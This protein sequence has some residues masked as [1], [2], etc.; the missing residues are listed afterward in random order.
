MSNRTVTNSA[1]EIFGAL[2]DPTRR[3]VLDLLCGGRQPA[4]RIAASFNVS[5]PAVTKHVRLLLRARL[6]REQ[7]E[8]RYRFYELNAEPL[9][10]VDSWLNRYKVFWSASLVGLKNYVESEGAKGISASKRNSNQTIRR[11]SK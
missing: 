2:A 9:K 10:A 4:G 7:R 6:I 5:R 8:G 11:P 1:G 3:A